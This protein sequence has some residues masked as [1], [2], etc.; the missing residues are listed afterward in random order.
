MGVLDEAIREHLELKRRHGAAED[1]LA[2]QEAEALGPARRDAPFAP[3][4][5][6]FAET[7]VIPAKVFDRDDGRGLADDVGD[8]LEEPLDAPPDE[9]QVMSEPGDD[10]D[11]VLAAP[12]VAEAR[13]EEPALDGA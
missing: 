5:D 12:P 2:R 3:G 8:E 9:T 1:E 13:V 10:E 11:L 7:T 4:G 6:E